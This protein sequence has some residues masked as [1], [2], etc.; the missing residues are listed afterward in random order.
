MFQDR[1]PTRED[2]QQTV[3]VPEFVLFDLQVHERSRRK[4]G[5]NQQTPIASN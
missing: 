3:P 1:K 2:R 5:I 4:I